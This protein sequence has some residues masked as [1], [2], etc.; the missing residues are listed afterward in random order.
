MAKFITGK[1]L[2]GTLGSLWRDLEVLRAQ[3]DDLVE[4][5]AIL[6]EEHAEV[7][8]QVAADVN[9][10][11]I[12]GAPVNAGQQANPGAPANRPQNANNP[13]NNND[14]NNAAQ[15]NAAG[16][17]LSI[18]FGVVA[19]N[20]LSS[21]ISPFLGHAVGQLLHQWALSRSTPGSGIMRK[22]LGVGLR[23]QI[24][25]IHAA[26]SHWWGAGAL[27]QGRSPYMPIGLRLGV[28]E[29][30]PIWYVERFQSLQQCPSIHFFCRNLSY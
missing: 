14:N 12:A 29:L 22:V 8:A 4:Q 17:V 1:D 21:L 26:A 23:G 28:E 3:R 30:D 15:P 13:A 11:A 18:T 7:V 20:L 24:S 19:R 25:T 6:E 2:D 9:V 10:E 16:R 27:T 5:Q